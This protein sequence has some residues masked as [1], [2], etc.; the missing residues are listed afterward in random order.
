M[1]LNIPL[2]EYQLNATLADEVIRIYGVPLKLI[3]SE[4]INEDSVF[5]DFSHL[6]VDNTSIFEIYGFPDNADEYEA[7]EA[8]SSNFGFMG[9]TNVDIYISKFSFDK[10][11]TDKKKGE[12]QLDKIVNSL[13]VLPSQKVLEI[14][15]LKVETPSINNL[16]MFNNLKNCYR[17]KCRSYHFKEQDELTSDMF[18]S[19]STNDDYL[20]T[21]ELKT[22]ESYFD[23]LTNIKEEQDL[24]TKEYMEN[25]DP[26]F[27]RF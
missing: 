27:G 25:P 13:I 14:T 11:F 20:D 5:G 21:N 23:E 19:N 4:K 3:L 17:L 10:L 7:G 9:E 1:N 8:L 22:L 15:D 26:V 16:F 24:E 18:N 6:K 12:I 2:N